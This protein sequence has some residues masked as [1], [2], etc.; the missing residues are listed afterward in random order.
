MRK[1]DRPAG[2]DVVASLK[3]LRDLRKLKDRIQDE[4]HLVLR[5]QNAEIEPDKSWLPDLV[6]RQ[7]VLPHLLGFR[8][9]PPRE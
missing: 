8:G 5:Q 6:T 7:D 4:F 1:E 3:L 2:I 9:N